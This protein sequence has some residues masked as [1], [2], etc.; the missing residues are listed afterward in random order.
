[1]QRVVRDVEVTPT[2]AGRIA[3]QPLT[4]AEERALRRARRLIPQ[5]AIADR[6]LVCE[7][8]Q[9]LRDDVRIEF[10]KR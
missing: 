4:Q 1:V 8:R 6:S 3:R 10:L 2:D 5:L 9:L 7:L